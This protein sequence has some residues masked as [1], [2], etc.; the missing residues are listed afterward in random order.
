MPNLCRIR[1]VWSGATGLPG[2][3]TWYCANEG[4]SGTVSD[5]RNAIGAFYAAVESHR[6]TGVLVTLE[7]AGDII[8]GTTGEIVGSWGDNTARVS[9]GTGSANYAAGVG[10]FVRART[11]VIIDG[12]RIRGGFYEAPLALDSFDVDGTLASSVVT[13]YNAA[14]LVLNSKLGVDFYVSSPARKAQTSPPRPATAYRQAPI[15]GWGIVDKSTML[16]SRRS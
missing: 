3:T 4:V 10:A 14:L 11:S 9:A 12:V 7:T 6:P 5:A 15:D 13:D 8:S 16:R 2:V 1:A